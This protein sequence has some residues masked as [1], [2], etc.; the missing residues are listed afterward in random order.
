M[1][2][3]VIHRILFSQQCK[4]LQVNTHTRDQS[5]FIIHF[6]VD[7]VYDLKKNK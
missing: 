1:L 5:V 7:L 4:L 3:N 2:F 6:H